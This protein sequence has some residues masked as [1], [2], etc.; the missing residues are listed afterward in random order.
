L[1]GY[2]GSIGVPTSGYFS[3][4]YNDIKSLSVR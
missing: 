4:K 1:R 2:F 3:I